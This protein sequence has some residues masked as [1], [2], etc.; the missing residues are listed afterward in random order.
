MNHLISFL[1]QSGTES[2]EP[3]FDPQSFGTYFGAFGGAAVGLLGGFFGS[4]GSWAA[5]RN[6]WRGLILGGMVLCGGLCSAALIV[7]L[8]A[9]TIGQPYGVWYPL[10]LIG[11]IGAICFL[12]L[13]PVMH[14]RYAQAENR[15]MEASALRNS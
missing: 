8:I 13:L 12:G 10:F 9:V 11:L 1:I 5:Q 2:T 4:V 14:K 6:K 3:W 15:R 7:G